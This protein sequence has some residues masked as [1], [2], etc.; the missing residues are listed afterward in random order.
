MCT[1]PHTDHMGCMARI[2]QRF[3]IGSLY[4]PLLPDDQTPTTRAYEKLLD[5]AEDKGLTII[6]LHED[7]LLE[8][9]AGAQFQVMAPRMDAVWEGANNYSS[10]LRLVYGKA[11]G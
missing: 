7:A 6:R 4:M 3:D 2:I 10:V 11:S 1:H 9:P 5:A 8:S